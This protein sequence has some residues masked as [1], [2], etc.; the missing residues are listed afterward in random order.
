MLRILIFL[1]P[2]F[3][4][5]ACENTPVDP[6]P[7]ELPKVAISSATFFEGDENTTKSF[8]VSISAIHTKD[9]SVDYATQEVSAGEQEDFLPVSGTLIIPA[10]ERSVSIEVTI[11]A[12]TLKEPDEAFKVVIS[13]PVQATITGAEATATIRNDDEFIFIPAEGYITPESYTGYNLTFQEEFDG[14]SLDP[15]V[16]TY[17]LGVGN[18]G[19]GN[20][21]SQYYTDRSENSKLQDG[22]L[23]ITAI[24][25]DFAGSPYTSARIKTQ[26]RMTFQH[27][28]VDVRAKLPQGQGIWPAIWMLGNDISSVGWPACGEIDI[29]ELVGHEP[30]TVHGTA[31]WGPQGRP[32]STFKGKGYSISEGIFADKYHVFSIIWEPGSIKWLV[33]DNEFF[34]LTNADVDGDYPFDDNFFF[35]LNIA[36]GGN[37]PGYPDGS[38]VFPQT[39]IVD[40]IRVFQKK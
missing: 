36:V 12:D 32:Y 19:W 2:L 34:S 28:R 13:N 20:N 4:L 10:G 23:I 14:A 15:D 11:V 7:T 22:K 31:H 21:E 26:D 29:M 37:W 40:Y 9:V 6:T 3:G 33:N 27:G 8:Q 38:T 35:I 16:W 17:D 1:L 25:E 30:Q 5:L 39:M 18:G 24:R